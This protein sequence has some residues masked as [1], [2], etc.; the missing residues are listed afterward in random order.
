MP[1]PVACGEDTRG[2]VPSRRAGRAPPR[3]AEGPLGEAPGADAPS[4][5]CPA[6][7]LSG[8][9]PSSPALTSF[10]PPGETQ[11]PSP[12]PA[13]APAP[14]RLGKHPSPSP[15]KCCCQGPQP[16][17]QA[18][19]EAMVCG[20]CRGWWGEGWGGRQKGAGGKGSGAGK[21]HRGRHPPPPHLQHG[22]G[23][24]GGALWAPH[25]PFSML[26]ES[27]ARYPA[28]TRPCLVPAA[29][30]ARYTGTQAGLG[31]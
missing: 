7:E 24:P 28:L 26:R 22:S 25:T 30:T 8:R 21:K 5:L 13:P 17:P 16:R 31:T 4:S 19:V 3:P 29:I 15:S 12:K 23:Q 6:G 10:Q 27:M 14:P 2:S 20:Q 18:C 11:A 9:D 1:V